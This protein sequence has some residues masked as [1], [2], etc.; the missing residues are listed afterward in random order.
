VLRQTPEDVAR[1]RPRIALFR[2]FGMN[3]T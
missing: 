1:F 2:Y 3:S